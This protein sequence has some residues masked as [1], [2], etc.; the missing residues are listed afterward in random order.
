MNKEDSHYI[1][2]GE[3]FLKNLFPCR[4]FILPPLQTVSYSSP[5]VR[6]G[7]AEQ[8]W[9]ILH[10]QQLWI[11]GIIAELKLQSSHYHL[12]SLSHSWPAARLLCCQPSRW[13]NLMWLSLLKM[14]AHML[15]AQ[16]LCHLTIPCL[17]VS[18]QTHCTHTVCSWQLSHSLHLMAQRVTSR[19]T[20]KTETT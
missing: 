11:C 13:L 4:L 12:C 10:P 16:I 14:S 2:E 20:Q 3:R 7:S 6:W 5:S 18:L 15:A 1:L 17:S 8:T 19:F 9:L